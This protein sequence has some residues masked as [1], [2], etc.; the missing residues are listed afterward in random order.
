MMTNGSGRIARWK[1]R[2]RALK[3][4][5]HAL[6]LACRD[7]RVPWPAKL[8]AALVVA[9]AA[10]PIDLIPDFIPVLGYLDDLILLPLGIVLAVKLIPA[11]VLEDCRDRAGEALPGT[12]A[13]A[14]IGATVVVVLWIT[15][16]VAVVVLGNKLMV[17]PSIF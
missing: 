7:P 16:I 15:V 13:G 5:V 8:V 14:F 11:G 4:E 17:G 6:L 3:T 1:A 2:V 12:R 9:Y 10:S